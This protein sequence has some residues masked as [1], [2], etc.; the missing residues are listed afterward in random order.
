MHK[1]FKMAQKFMITHGQIDLKQP[2]LTILLA[3]GKRFISPISKNIKHGNT[4]F[5]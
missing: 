4:T 1:A 3:Q 5:F 2:L